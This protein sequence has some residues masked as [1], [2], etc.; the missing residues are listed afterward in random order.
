M[1]PDNNGA[2]CMPSCEP[3]VSPRQNEILIKFSA[4]L[5]AAVLADWLFYGHSLGASVTLFLAALASFAALTNPVKASWRQ[6]SLAVAV[7]VA[8]LLPSL[9]EASWLSIIFGVAGTAYA[10]LML[11]RPEVNWFERIGESISLA[12]SGIFRVFGDLSGIGKALPGGEKLADKSKF[13]IVWIVPLVFG[14]IFLM[15]FS[16][17]N[18]LIDGWLSAIDL[19]ALFEH[20]SVARIA[21]WLTATM[22]VWPFI[23]IR[24]NNVRAIVAREFAA[25]GVNGEQAYK[26]RDANKGLFET[27]FTPAAILRSLIVFNILFAAQTVMDGAYLWGGLSLPSGLTHAAYAHRGAYPLIFTALLAAAFVIIAMRPGSEAERSPLIRVLVFVWTGQNVVLVIS[28]ILRLD[29]YVQEYSLTYLRLAAFVWMLLVGLG[30][31]LIVAR[32]VFR[33]SNS[34]LVRANLVSLGLTLY[35]CCFIN[36]PRAIADYNVD[37]CRELSGHG[38]WLDTSYLFS[39]GPQVLPS[40]DRYLA[41]PFI[42]LPL[43]Q[44]QLPE[45]MAIAH[46]AR[47]QDWRSWTLRDWELGLYFIANAD[48]QRW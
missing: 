34:W 30:L 25:M 19:R 48:L 42:A 15:L 35:L 27:L 41:K 44:K 17:A 16:S 29:L 28:S 10:A 20:V 47:M 6:V 12:L 26:S 1:Q 36:F 33:R 7:L 5:A 38:T 37:H 18:P 45:Q 8:A 2:L 32:I 40:I 21:F 23:F 39:L 24:L 46:A 13:L 11:A 14:V 9:V 31:A 43:H 22:A 3:E 4:I